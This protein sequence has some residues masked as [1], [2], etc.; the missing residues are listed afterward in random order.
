MRSSSKIYRNEV[1]SKKMN[2]KK[3][4]GQLVPSRTKVKYH[5]LLEYPKILNTD[6]FL[7]TNKDYKEI[8]NHHHDDEH[9]FLFLDPP[10]LN[11]TGDVDKYGCIFTIEDLEYI[12]SFMSSC[13]CKVM[14]IID[15][16]GYT[17]VLFQKFLKGLYPVRYLTQRS[18]KADLVYTKY[19]GIFTN[20]VIE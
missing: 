19:H 12:S 20:Y 7:V 6:K 8:L 16:T 18:E 15:F 5:K 11:R 14:V 10:Y 2:M 1:D 13:K 9:A 4:D 17:F 3:V